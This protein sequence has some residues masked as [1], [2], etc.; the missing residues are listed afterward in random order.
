[1][2]CTPASEIAAPAELQSGV[3]ASAQ[4]DVAPMSM[5]RSHL[6]A[7]Q[8]QD[9][10]AFQAQRSLLPYAAACAPVI[11]TSVL[12]P[13]WLA[14]LMAPP[15]AYALYRITLSL[16]AELFAIPARRG[17]L[18]YALPLNVLLMLWSTALT[19]AGQ[20]AA[21]ASTAIPWMALL[22]LCAAPACRWSR[23][24][25]TRRI[26]LRWSFGFTAV[27]VLA[28]QGAA[29]LTQLSELTWLKGW[30]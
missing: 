18:A 28:A 9:F 7:L 4:P 25:S 14:L 23:G 5:L 26:P 1:M 3:V 2:N 12:A 11:A 15:S 10:S 29:A 19:A 21:V 27:A 17:F 16:D 24:R 6:L 8:G 13:A 20:M 22:C 30:L